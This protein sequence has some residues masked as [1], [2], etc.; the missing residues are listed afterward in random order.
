[1]ISKIE[2]VIRKI[3]KTEKMRLSIFFFKLVYLIRNEG[4]VCAFI[5]IKKEYS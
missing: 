1:M 3:T 2:K 4:K 5:N